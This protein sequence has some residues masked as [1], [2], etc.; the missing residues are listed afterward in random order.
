MLTLLLVV[1]TLVVVCESMS[2]VSF[3]VDSTKPFLV[4]YGSTSVNYMV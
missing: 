4:E 2:C 1:N 3:V